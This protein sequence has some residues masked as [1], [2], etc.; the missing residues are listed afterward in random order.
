MGYIFSV[1]LTQSLT[2]VTSTNTY[3]TCEGLHACQIRDQYIFVFAIN[4]RE[5]PYHIVGTKCSCSTLI[6]TLFQKKESIR[7]K[8]Q[9]QN[10]LCFLLCNNFLLLLFFFTYLFWSFMKESNIFFPF[11]L[12]PC[13]STPNLPTAFAMAM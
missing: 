2:I 7:S 10:S 3:I 5:S 12:Q 9:Q 11:N 6:H 8:P 13:P 1:K 4:K